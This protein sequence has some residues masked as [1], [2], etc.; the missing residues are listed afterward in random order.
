MKLVFAISHLDIVLFLLLF[1]TSQSE[2][3][4]EDVLN[5][6]GLQG[7]RADAVY[8]MLVDAGKVGP[9]GAHTISQH[10]LSGMDQCSVDFASSSACVS[11]TIKLA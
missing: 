9:S 11:S 10:C 1:H 3:L 6:T 5:I 2:L 4:I 8:N 7:E